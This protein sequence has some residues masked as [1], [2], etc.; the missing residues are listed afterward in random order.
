VHVIEFD[1]QTNKITR[2][3]INYH[4]GV[5]ENMIADENDHFFICYKESNRIY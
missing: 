2:N 4:K 1:D 3:Y 5:L